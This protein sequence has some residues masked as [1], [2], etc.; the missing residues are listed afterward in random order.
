MR[1]PQTCRRR[2]RPVARELAP[3]FWCL[4]WVFALACQDSGAS[5]EADAA[6][7]F[8]APDAAVLEADAARADGGPVDA[9]VVDAAADAAPMDARADAAP[10][11]GPDATPDA[12]LA[13][14]G[15]AFLWRGLQHEWL[16]R[17]AGFRIPHRISKLDSYI[18]AETFEA[19][20]GQATFNFGQATGVDGNYM[21]PIG[22]F[23][24]VSA[25]GL[26][27]VR[28]S[29]LAEWIDTSDGAEHPQARSDEALRFQVDLA[30]DFDAHAVV[31][32]GIR[33][34]SHC[35]PANQPADEPCNSNGLW[36]FRMHFEVGPC[37]VQGR[38]LDCGALIRIHRAWTPN[39]GG[40]PPIEIKPFNHRLDFEVELFWTALAGPSQV[41]AAHRGAPISVPGR[42]RDEAP[43]VGQAELSG[44]DGGLYPAGLIAPVAFGFEFTRTGDA[45]RFQHLGRYIGA[46]HFDLRDEAY[47]ADTGVLGYRH[48][49]RVW[50][51]D[52]VAATDVVYTHQGSLLQFADPLAAGPHRRA[53]GSLCSNSSDQAPAFSR[54]TQCGE[55]DK[56]PERAAHA[57]EIEAP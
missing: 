43:V 2:A 21:R 15:G 32:R 52:T 51:P 53:Q 5:V 57:V 23:A 29:V 16:R 41:F 25:R 35:D 54:W 38:S 34:E 50:V 45:D 46:L 28:G 40:L 36:P 13:P 31:L 3:L 8:T 9:G 33:L 20:S 22:S 27:V 55:A 56:G 47:D 30:E 1:S 10:D 26:Q 19:R 12:E 4:P 42:A 14:I 24:S 44:V 37:E 11:A 48:T 18:D 49:S 39:R 6:S 17:V 7:V